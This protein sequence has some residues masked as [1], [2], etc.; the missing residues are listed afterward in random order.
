MKKTTIVLL[1]T[2]LSVMPIAAQES[3]PVQEPPVNYRIISSDD[4]IT[5]NGA[6]NIDSPIQKTQAINANFIYDDDELFT[7]LTRSVAV[8][9]IRLQ[10]DEQ[11]EAIHAGDT[12]RFI[13]HRF[14][15]SIYI[16]PIISGITTTGHIRTNKRNY[17]FLIISVEPGENFHSN[18]S[19]DTPSLVVNEI[20][21]TERKKREVE[22]HAE[23]VALIAE[24]RDKPDIIAEFLSHTK[25]F[26]DIVG[27]SQIAPQYALSDK[28]KT[29]F[30][31]ADDQE[32]PAIFA[33]DGDGKQT[34][35]NYS[36][37]YGTLLIADRVADKWEF[38][39]GDLRAY[40]QRP[41]SE[42]SGFFGGKASR[43]RTNGNR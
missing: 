14:G 22:E 18:V 21:P 38:V 16:K 4:Q 20:S 17:S 28:N 26:Y 40:A 41:N 19:W 31:F 33:L 25:E 3:A 39:L 37:K 24:D 27:D 7:I 2:A 6:S 15:N 12:E 32:L 35:V 9:H 10:P 13:F 11:Y 30:K 8:T 36:A 1:S 43:N 34:V 29:F 42:S 5:G 23:T